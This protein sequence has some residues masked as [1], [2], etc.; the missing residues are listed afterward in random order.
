MQSKKLSM[1]IEALIVTLAIA[2]CQSS[3]SEVN[4]TKLSLH[5]DPLVVTQLF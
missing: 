5:Q 3:L 4:T 1:V 2:I